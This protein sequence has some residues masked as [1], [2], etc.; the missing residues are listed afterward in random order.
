LSTSASPL[1]AIVLS[2]KWA[3]FQGFDGTSIKGEARGLATFADV[4]IH[5]RTFSEANEYAIRTHDPAFEDGNDAGDNLNASRVTAL[6]GLRAGAALAREPSSPGL[7]RVR[8]PPFP[9]NPTT[10][11]VF[12]R[13]RPSAAE[14]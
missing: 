10:F 2:T 7:R 8:R 9:A 11:T 13:Q 1:M 12:A 4:V 3:C 5:D 6:L 14:D